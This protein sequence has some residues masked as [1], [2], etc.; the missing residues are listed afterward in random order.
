[1]K[2]LFYRRERSVSCMGDYYTIR[3]EIM[4]MLCIKMPIMP[5]WVHRSVLIVERKVGGLLWRYYVLSGPSF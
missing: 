1:M 2:Q 5:G 4:A 3:I